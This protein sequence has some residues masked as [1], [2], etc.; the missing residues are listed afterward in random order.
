MQA[1]VII[2][3]APGVMHA[4]PLSS[5]ELTLVLRA[6]A[7]VL[8]PLPQSTAEHGAALVAPLSP[9]APVAPIAVEL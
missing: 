7:E 4:M 1:A 5:N 9:A 8:L 2:H 3:A 6:M